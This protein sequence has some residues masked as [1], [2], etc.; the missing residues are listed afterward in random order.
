MK[1]IDTPLQ[2]CFIIEPTVFEDERGYFFESFNQKKFETLLGEKINFVQDNES[3]SQQGT[4]RGLHMQEGPYAQAK[5]VRVIQGK[6][7]DIAVDLRKNAP[8]YGQY[9]SVLL[10]GENKKQLFV[11]RGFAHG[12]V[13]L[14]KEAVFSYKCDNMYNKASEVG[15]AFDDADLAIDWQYDLTKVLLSEKDQNNMSFQE[16]TN[17]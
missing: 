16:Y 1:R 3:K 2:G 7:L 17:A 4:L 14:S 10:S 12:F 9:F 8:T 11:P 5:L 6:V 15:V 13:T